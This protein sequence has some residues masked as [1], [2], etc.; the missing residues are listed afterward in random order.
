MEAGGSD[1]APEVQDP[2]QWPANIGSER[3]WA[4]ASAPEEQLN[5]RS[6]PL[7]MGK[8]LGGGSSINVMVWARGHRSDWEYYAEQANDASWGYASVLEIYKRIEDWHGTPDPTFRGSGGPVFVQPPEAPG[9]LGA[10]T[11]EAAK[12]VGIPVFESQN[13]LMMEGDGGAARMD[14]IIKHGRR[15]SIFR[16]YTA[17][18]LG[19]PNLT[20]LSNTLVTRLTFEGKRVTGV[21]IATEGKTSRVAANIEVVVSLGALQTPRLLMQ[22][23]IGHAEHLRQFG[24]PLVQHL[25]GVGQNLQD[26]VNFGCTWESQEPI[27][28]DNNVSATTLY[29]KSDPSLEAPDLMHCQAALPVPNPDTAYIGQTEN[30]W[31]TFAGV[32]R[33]HSRGAVSLTGRNPDDPLHIRTHA[34]S[35]P[36]DI[37]AA[38]AT[39]ALCRE[40]GNAPPLRTIAKREVIPGNLQGRDLQNFLRNAAV[41]FW[42]QTCTAKMG[43]DEDSVVD[44]NL[45]VYGTEGLRVADGSILPR[46]T[47]GNTM[48]PCV[49]IGERAA[50]IILQKYRA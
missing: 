40:I 39:V 37:K 50:D 20:V 8:V 44:S 45:A 6:L 19:R 7:S 26:H 17:P 24:I 18:L 11:L 16:A 14:L 5:G 36:D 30:G 33:P 32:A 38:L 10:A 46:I 22:S 23:G 1:E 13:G 12:S 15:H 2:L 41:T 28:K 29:W 27:P 9:P 47:T 34:L 25:P 43:R 21:E 49:V 3:D 35:H 4:F 31:T 42:H 48:A